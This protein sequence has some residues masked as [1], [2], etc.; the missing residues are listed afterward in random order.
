MGKP[1]RVTDIALTLGIS[2][3]SVNKAIRGLKEIEYIYH[4]YY[5]TIRLTPE[6]KAA[7]VEIW[8]AYQAAYTFLV[9]IL[10]VSEDEAREEACQIGHV[11][12]KDTCHKLQILIKEHE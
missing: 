7:A 3:A 11:L 6:G 10:H 5:S 8:E 9:D 12:K 4:E 1:V 2:K